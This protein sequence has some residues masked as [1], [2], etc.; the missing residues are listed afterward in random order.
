[1]Q[2]IVGD[3]SSLILLAKAGILNE[4]LQ[5]TDIIIPTVV[6]NEIMKG[7][8]KNKQDAFYIEQYININKIKIIDPAPKNILKISQLCNLDTGELHAITLAK[9]ANLNILIDDRKGIIVCNRLAI[10]MHT[11]LLILNELAI[12]KLINNTKIEFALNILM[13]EGRYRDNEINFVFT[14]LKERGFL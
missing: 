8:E 6:Y 4:L 10:R 7:K 1:M 14:N 2:L 5:F 13:R 12:E 9:E 3:S 11:A